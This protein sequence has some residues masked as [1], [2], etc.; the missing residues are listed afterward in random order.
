MASRF[1]ERCSCALPPPALGPEEI[2]EE[3]GE[4]GRALGEA[5]HEIGKPVAAERDVNAEAVA[6]LDELALQ[7]D[8]HAV[9]HLELE[10]VLGDFLCGREANGLCDHARI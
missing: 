7:V 2:A 4:I 8:S 1:A 10:I 6:V 9:Q 3:E 5:A